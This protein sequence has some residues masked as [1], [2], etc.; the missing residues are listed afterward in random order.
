[1]SFSLAY[2]QTTAEE[3]VLDTLRLCFER[4][5]ANQTRSLVSKLMTQHGEDAGSFANIFLREVLVVALHGV[6]HTGSE[7]GD[8]YLGRYLGSADGSAKSSPMGSGGGG[9]GGGLRDAA[10]RASQLGTVA[11]PP[12]SSIA[13]DYDFA[14]K[15]AGSGSDIPSHSSASSDAGDA[16]SHS[17]DLMRGE[18][19]ETTPPVP[20][21]AASDALDDVFIAVAQFV[22]AET[23]RL[24]DSE[25]PPPAAAASLV[26]TYEAAYRLAEDVLALLDVA[27]AQRGLCSLH[28]QH[29]LTPLQ[30]Q[31]LDAAFV[32]LAAHALQRLVADHFDVETRRW[33]TEDLDLQ[34]GEE[35]R[36]LSPSA[37][38]SAS[39]GRY[40]AS[41]ATPAKAAA[42]APVAAWDLPQS[43]MESLFRRGYGGLGQSRLGDVIDLLEGRDDAS[44]ASAASVDSDADAVRL[45]DLPTAPIAVA[46]RPPD[47]SDD[48]A[49]DD[50]S[51]GF[52]LSPQSPL[53][54]SRPPDASALELF[55]PPRADAPPA[56]R[57]TKKPRRAA[58][59][60]SR[61][62]PLPTSAK[63]PAHAPLQQL[64]QQQQTQQRPAKAARVKPKA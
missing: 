28:L 36:L 14:D 49:S 37:Q 54:A 57:K 50:D 32:S 11:L 39:A 12:L 58:A 42:E 62:A 55:S 34:E 59:T 1:M 41:E 23:Q 60:K 33:R 56:Q 51:D 63:R 48:D 25:L 6:E 35:L 44:A 10:P 43:P 16:D 40:A 52:A 21:S 38:L 7:D 31:Q 26:L 18:V 27:P 46:S 61:K 4:A 53:P 30:G 29:A 3:A 15:S 64:V 47:D 19:G 9:G 22:A 5:D 2:K 20:P 45:D 17:D 24:R 8:R 13:S